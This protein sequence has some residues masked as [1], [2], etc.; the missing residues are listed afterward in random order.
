MNIAAVYD[1]VAVSAGSPGRW[2]DLTPLAREAVETMAAAVVTGATD[3]A[4]VADA[5]VR[6]LAETYHLDVGEG[7]AETYLLVA[8][9]LV[10]AAAVPP[11]VWADSLPTVVLA[12]PVPGAYLLPEDAYHADPLRG[13]GRSVNASTLRRIQPPGCPALV[14][15]ERDHPVHRDAY[16]LGTVTH[17]LTLGSG[18]EVIELPYK[19][20]QLKAAKQERDAARERGAVALLAR[21][22]Q[23][24]REM[25]S[26]V[27]THPLAGGLLRVPGASEVTLIWREPVPGTDREVWARC[28]IDRH[29]D[30]TIINVTGD[31]KTSSTDLDADS[32]IRKSWDYSY[33]Q[34]VEWYGRGYQSVHG[35]PLEGFWLLFV[36][37]TPPHLVHV[38]QLDVDLLAMARAAND[39]ALQVWDDCQQSGHWPGPGDDIEPTLLTAPRWAR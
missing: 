5:A 19:S 33:H 12:E 10:E 32:L 20:W 29:P 9:A 18:P 38:V 4:V 22:Y 37:T 30:P 16:D 26:A 27:R 3:P 34:A 1:Q 13:H 25:A 14:A 21:D 36:R 23:A 17:R 15:W 39:R 2:A 24:A 7:A 8:A 11:S 35:V 28:M 31:L 6:H